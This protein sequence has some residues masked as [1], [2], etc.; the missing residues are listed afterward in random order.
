MPD[1]RLPRPMLHQRGIVD[2]G[3]SDGAKLTHEE[4]P[5]GGADAAKEGTLEMIPEADMKP[6]SRNVTMVRVDSLAI[7]KLLPDF[8]PPERKDRCSCPART[9]RRSHLPQGWRY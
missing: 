6:L 9:A 1:K 2:R 7:L 8:I 5:G 4:R 3:H